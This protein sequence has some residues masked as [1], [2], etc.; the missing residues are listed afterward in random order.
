MYATIKKMVEACA[1]DPTDEAIAKAVGVT[2]RD[3]DSFLKLMLDIESWIRYE[4]MTLN[5]RAY[6]VDAASLFHM[7]FVPKNISGRLYYVN[8][9]KKIIH[10]GSLLNKS[11]LRKRR[12]GVMNWSHNKPVHYGKG[13]VLEA[14]A[15][16]TRHVILANID[17]MQITR[18]IKLI[19]RANIKNYTILNA[20]KSF[21]FTL[22]SY[23]IEREV[24]TVGLPEVKC[25]VVE[26]RE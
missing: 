23:A 22:R 26:Y 19:V 5:Q 7:M 13:Y 2:T 3:L 14:K 12:S 11:V 21:L 6:T 25:K 20:I 8:E 24:I 10:R 15:P 9:A 17:Q 16:S 18:S 1:K 4:G